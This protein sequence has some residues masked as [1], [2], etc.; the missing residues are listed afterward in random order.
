[1]LAAAHAVGVSY[2]TAVFAFGTTFAVATLVPVWALAKRI[3]PEPAALAAPLLL[4]AHPGFAMWAVHGLETSLFVFLTASSVWAASVA[5]DAPEGRDATRIS[6]LAGALAGLAFWTRPEG[7]LWAIA[8]STYAFLRGRRR[9]AIAALTVFAAFAVPLEIAR[10]LYYGALFPNTFYAKEGGGLGRFGFGLGYAKTFVVSH[11]LVV[12]ACAV[13]GFA[14]LRRE[15]RAAAPPL[16]LFGCGFGLLWSAYVV[17]MGGDA[18]PGYRFWLPILPL[19]GVLVAHALAKREALALVAGVAVVAVTAWAA[20]ADVRLEHETGREFTAKMTA[21]GTWLRDHVPP[22][23]VVAVNYVGALPY[24]SGLPTIDM[25]G[26]TDP[27]IAHTAI[28][29]R[30]RFPGHAKG[31]GASVLDRQPGLILMGGVSLG[32]E[33]VRELRTEL[34][35]EDEIAA[36]SRFAAEYELVN[37]EVPGPDGP[38]WLGFYRRKDAAWPPALAKEP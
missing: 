18:F 27:A 9:E 3:A 11:V 35:S 8:V 6:R 24:Y 28:R 14:L 33:P 36:D 30:F 16:V 22:G 15:T 29:G 23:T 26:L 4:A 5:W 21:A 7:A 17:W 13:A 37:V 10:C 1:M 32:P 31:N 34:A 2:E 25:L 19:A 38:A 20:R 12:A